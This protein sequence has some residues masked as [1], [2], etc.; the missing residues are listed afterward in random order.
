MSTPRQSRQDPSTW[1][2]WR[3]WLMWRR[4]ITQSPGKRNWDHTFGGQG[5][6]KKFVMPVSSDVSL[7]PD[8]QDWLAPGWPSQRCW[9]S[10]SW[11]VWSASSSTGWPWT[12]PSPT[13]TKA[14]YM[15]G[16]DWSRDQ[17]NGLW[18]V[19]TD[20]V[21]RV[22]ASDWSK[23]ITWPEYWPLIGRDSIFPLRAHWKRAW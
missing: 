13:W 11:S 12:S 9:P 2:S 10:W 4:P 6:D 15:I 18:L 19:N 23:L 7:S 1:P 21:T 22:L 17:N 5:L 8:S 3:K 14:R 20:H 16:Q